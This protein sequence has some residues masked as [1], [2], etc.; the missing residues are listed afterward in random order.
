MNLRRVGT[1]SGHTIKARDLDEDFECADDKKHKRQ[2]YRG[3][4][5]H[6]VADGLDGERLV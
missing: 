5:D 1:P 2:G 4:V 6:D 3:A